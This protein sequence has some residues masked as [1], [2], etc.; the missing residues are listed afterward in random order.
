MLVMQ[1]AT[2]A[3]QKLLALVKPTHE[4]YCKRHGYE[5][6]TDTT[7]W[8]SKCFPHWG[9]F[10]VLQKLFKELPEDTIVLYMDTDAIIVDATYQLH[11]IPDGVSHFTMAKNQTVCYS[12]MQDGVFFARNTKEV[13]DFIDLLLAE[14]VTIPE[15]SPAFRANYKDEETFNARYPEHPEIKIQVMDSRF[16]YYPWISKDLC[17]MPPVIKAWHGMPMR[18]KISQM[19]NFCIS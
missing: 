2:G 8:S 17:T 11:T 13:R 14:A 19:P 9:K 1:H 16:N 4:A 3:D 7:S 10:F 5:Y 18:F 6:I 15:G 12:I